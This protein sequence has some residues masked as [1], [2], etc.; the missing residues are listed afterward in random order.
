MTPGD[1]GARFTREKE[2]LASLLEA[3][4]RCVYFLEASE[5]RI[6][7]PLSD[8]ILA[9]KKKDTEL[10]E[11]LSAINE[12]FSKLQDTLGLAMRQSLLLSGE[13]TESFLKVLAFFEKKQVVKSVEEWQ[14]AR[15]ARNIA[16]HTYEIA[17]GE[18]A[19]H[20]NMLHSLK[21]SLYG[22]A[23][24]FALYCQEELGISASSM[25]FQAEFMEITEGL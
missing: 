5:Q 21:G 17:Y 6:A 8:E 4:E 22:I 1:A 9:L 7:W 11:S 18:A 19:E 12:R 13:S 23:R 20:F 24:R 2:Y 3:I 16:A 10:F 25:D 15:T 14:V